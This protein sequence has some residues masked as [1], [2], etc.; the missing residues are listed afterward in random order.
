MIFEERDGVTY[1]ADASYAY[2]DDGGLR[3]TSTTMGAYTIGPRGGKHYVFRGSVRE[4]DRQL[5]IL[6]RLRD[7][8]SDV[9]QT[10]SREQLA[11]NRAR[12]Q[13]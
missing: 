13:R 5:D 4:L 9:P 6:M 2:T 7:R 10:V 3:L 12:A 8:V 1:G 11:I